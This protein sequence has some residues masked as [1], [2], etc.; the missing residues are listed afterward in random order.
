M[1]STKITKG[2]ETKKKIYNTAIKLFE[3]NGIENVSVNNIVKEAGISKGAFYVHYESKFSLIQ[4]YVNSLDLNYEEYFEGIPKDTSA[5]SMIILVT[6]KTIQVLT[7]DIGYSILTNVYKSM[8][9][10]E[11]NSYDILNY[12]R[13]LPDIY[14]KIIVKGINEGEFSPSINVD[15]LTQQLIISIRG[16]TFEWCIHSGKFDLTKKLIAHFKLL[17]EGFK[18][19]VI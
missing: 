6:E 12:N 17:L 4:E 7:E 14:K 1:E 15:S 9:S 3:M 19:H 16:M 8:L 18:N 2:M 11:F 10:S 5:S 13:S